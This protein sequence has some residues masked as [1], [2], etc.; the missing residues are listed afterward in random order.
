MSRVAAD[1]IVVALVGTN[2]DGAI[3]AYDA[4]TR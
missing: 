2:D 4:A 3:M 1:G